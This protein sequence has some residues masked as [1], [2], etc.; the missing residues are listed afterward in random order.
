MIKAVTGSLSIKHGETSYSA[1]FE[2]NGWIAAEL[3]QYLDDLF[4]AD[5]IEV[6]ILKLLGYTL[7]MTKVPPPR[8][9]DHWIEID[10]EKRTLATNSKLL[11]RA[12]KQQSPREDEPYWEPALKRIY[13][14]LDAHDFTVQLFR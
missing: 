12:V 13:N 4:R 7:Q 10:I 9:A 5:S 6:G 2:T 3:V 14:V 11:R 8:K 1:K